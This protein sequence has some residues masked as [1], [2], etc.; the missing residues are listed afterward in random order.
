MHISEGILYNLDI[1]HKISEKSC[2]ARDELQ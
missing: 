1:I 2:N